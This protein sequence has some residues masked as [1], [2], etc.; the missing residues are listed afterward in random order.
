MKAVDS[1]LHANR[2]HTQSL[3]PLGAKGHEKRPVPQATF[4]WERSREP[5]CTQRQATCVVRPASED[6]SGV[7]ASPY[8]SHEWGSGW[9]YGRGGGGRETGRAEEGVKDEGNVRR[10]ATN[11][12][13]PRRAARPL[14]SHPEGPSSI[15]VPLPRPALRA[16]TL[17]HSHSATPYYPRALREKLQCR[18][19]LSSQPPNLS[20]GRAGGVRP[21]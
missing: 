6:H 12:F 9:L 18:S 5:P 3:R 13:P 8:P 19:R 1:W 17:A 14:L 4:R 11:H 15:L 10:G 20:V 2:G 21:R 16:I 7:V